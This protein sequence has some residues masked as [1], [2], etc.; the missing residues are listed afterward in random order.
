MVRVHWVFPSASITVICISRAVRGPLNF[1]I[2]KLC[3]VNT[4]PGTRYWFFS[5]TSASLN[6]PE[7]NGEVVGRA[8]DVTFTRGEVGVLVETL[9]ESGV[10][11]RFDNLRFTPAE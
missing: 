8:Y 9:G 10:K 5:L 3:L 7:V 11:V 2:E 6:G 1:R 4:V